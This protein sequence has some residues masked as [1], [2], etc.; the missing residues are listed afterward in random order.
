MMFTAFLL[1]KDAMRGAHAT[2]AK[3]VRQVATQYGVMTLCIEHTD[4]DLVG[5]K[6]LYLCLQSPYSYC[7]DS[8]NYASKKPRV[9]LFQRG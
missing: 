8:L 6:R 7:Q 4:A 1:E 2:N 5:S 9:W 3:P